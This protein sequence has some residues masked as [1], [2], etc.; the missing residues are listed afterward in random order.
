MSPLNSCFAA[1]RLHGGLSSLTTSRSLRRRLFVAAFAALAA[2]LLSLAAGTSEANAAGLIIGAGQQLIAADPAD[3]KNFGL[4]VAIDGDAAA[5]GAP[6]DTTRGESAGAVYLFVRSA[7]TWQPHSTPKVFGPDGAAADNFGASVALSGGVMVVGAPSRSSTAGT[8]YIFRRA[9]AAATSAWS[10]E[11]QLTPAGLLPA[12]NFGNS[13]AVSGDTAIIGSPGDT[14]NSGAAYVFFRTGGNPLWTAQGSKLV[15]SPR[16]PEA[17]FG[18]SVALDADTAL[19]GSPAQTDPGAA[20]IFQRSGATWSA[21]QSLVVPPALGTPI[22]GDTFGRA[23][24]LSGNWALVGAPG[25]NVNFVSDAGSAFFFERVGTTWTARQRIDT[26]TAVDTGE[27]GTSVALSGTRVAVGAPLENNEKGQVHIYSRSA[28]TWTRTTP[29]IG[30]I[31]SEFAGFGS[32]VAVSPNAVLTGAAQEPCVQQVCEGEG[33]A[34]VF[35]LS[36]LPPVPLMGAR[37]A[38]VLVGL[39]VIAGSILRRQRRETR[40]TSAAGAPV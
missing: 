17:S 35:S 10:A 30:F 20:F 36:D 24:T 16:V 4:A 7:G 2:P 14:T 27:F 33:A 28:T 1:G 38:A 13:V 11:Q 29:P 8:A 34:Y 37:A 5:V 40:R 32:A 9:A 39:L 12:D 18:L 6:E 23:V 25:T 22:S 26:P 19:V 31:G 3:F 21:G 15:A